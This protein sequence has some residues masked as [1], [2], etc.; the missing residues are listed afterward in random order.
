VPEHRVNNAGVDLLNTEAGKQILRDLV[1]K[2]DVLVENFRAGTMDKLC[3]G[4]D[5]LKGSIHG[6]STR[7]FLG[8][9]R[10]A[11]SGDARP[12]TTV[13]RPPAVSGR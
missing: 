13:R 2:A 5:D 9:A 4:Y 12:T 8:T 1:A 6:W 10:R 7:Q 11:L 3:L